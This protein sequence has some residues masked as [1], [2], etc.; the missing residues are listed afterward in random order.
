MADFLWVT[1]DWRQL[2]LNWNRQIRCVYTGCA[3]FRIAGSSCF[4]FVF[5]YQVDARFIAELILIQK[6]IEQVLLKKSYLA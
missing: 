5:F 4:F 1:M 6:T 2:Q 3:L